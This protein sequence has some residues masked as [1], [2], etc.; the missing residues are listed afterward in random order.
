[1]KIDD[2]K[3]EQR[4]MISRFGV[5]T[6]YVLEMLGEYEKSPDNVSDYWKDFF[7]SMNA[8][9]NGKKESKSAASKLFSRNRSP[10]ITPCRFAERESR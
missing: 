8:G 1:M 5:N 9:T 2:L 6:W 10:E 7:G 3:P 4:E